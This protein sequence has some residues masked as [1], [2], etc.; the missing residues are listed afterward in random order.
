MQNK[1]KLKKL[2][3]IFGELLKIKGNEWLIDAILEKINWTSTID[4]ISKHS[5]ILDIHEHCV[6]EKIEKQAIEF[7]SDFKIDSIKQQLVDDFKKME[8]ERR[9][10]DFEG[11]CLCLYQ[12]F[13][14]IVN[15]LFSDFYGKEWNNFKNN[16]VIKYKDKDTNEDV[17]ITLEQEVIGNSKSFGA[18][19]KFKAVAFYYYFNKKTPLPY[20]YRSLKEGF[21]EIYQ[22]R[23]KNHREGELYNFQTEILDK[24]EGNESKY[25]FKFYGFLE[26]FIRTINCNLDNQNLSNKLNQK[27]TTEEQRNTIGA[28]NTALQELQNKMNKKK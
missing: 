27:R 20:S 7:Y 8:H 2:I 10:D 1:E 24:I 19:P 16:N 28:N 17:H 22:M 14:A 5:V 21:Y 13:E 3:D 11:F 26:D 18:Y 23:N 9:R 12:Q 25:Y 15:Y 4:E 6:E